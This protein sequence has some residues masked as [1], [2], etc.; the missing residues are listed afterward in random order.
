MRSF[1]IE[2]PSLFILAF[3]HIRIKNEI[4]DKKE[5]MSADKYDKCFFHISFSH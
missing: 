1:P 2:H 3:I 5:E 4:F